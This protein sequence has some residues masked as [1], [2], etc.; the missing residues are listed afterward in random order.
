M[1]LSESSASTDWYCLR[2]LL[3]E[4][5]LFILFLPCPR[6]KRKSWIAEVDANVSHC[7]VSVVRK[8][9]TISLPKS[10]QKPRKIWAQH[11]LVLSSSGL[12]CPYQAIYCTNGAV[13]IQHHK[14]SCQGTSRPHLR[15]CKGD[16]QSHKF[17]L[18]LI[19]KWICFLSCSF[20]ARAVNK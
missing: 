3:D 13:L 14:K 9:T 7:L 12:F 16:C 10:Q 15:N 8:L 1:V 17:S 20:C 2:Q 19:S 6:G 18:Q 5:S 11:K 4:F